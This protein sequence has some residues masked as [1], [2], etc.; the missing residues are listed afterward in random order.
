MTLQ[1]ICKDKNLSTDKNTVHNYFCIYEKLFHPIKD[2]KLNILELGV[3]K[4]HSLVLWLEYFKNSN[5][6][7]VD[8]KLRRQR[9]DEIFK[10]YLGLENIRLFLYTFNINE[11]DQFNVFKDIKFDIIIEDGNHDISQQMALFDC[12]KPRLSHGGIYITEDISISN[13]KPWYDKMQKEEKPR[14]NYIFIDLREYRQTTDNIL[15][16]YKHEDKLIL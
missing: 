4:G 14:H 3:H 15:M 1:E 16:I 8:W 5:V 2:N 11:T 12:L 6:Y 9:E 10:H 7:G 13:L